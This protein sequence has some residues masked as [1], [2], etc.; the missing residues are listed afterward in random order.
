MGRRHQVQIKVNEKWQAFE[1]ESSD[2]LVDVLRE[3]LGL[4]GTKLGCGKGD[5]CACTVLLNNA[6]VNSCLVLAV[7]ADQKEV[8]TV[9]GLGKEGRDPLQRAFVEHSAIQCG[10]CTP[11]MLLSAKA[12]LNETP[13]PTEGEIKRGISGNLCRC[14]GYVQII[15]AIQS[16]TG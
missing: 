2:R 11:G 1:V 9:E 15:E 14:T 5:C 3:R 6:P 8:I 16:V 7:Q 12:L 10:Y 13:H 4:T